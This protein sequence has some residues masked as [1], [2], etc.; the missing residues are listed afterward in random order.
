MGFLH[1]L[2]RRDAELDEEIKAHLT[3]AVRDRV[4]RGEDPAAAERAVRLEFGNATAIR[5]STRE[6]WGFGWLEEIGR[7]LRYALRGMRGSPGVTAVILLSMALGIGANTAMFSLV[8]SVM[9]RALPVSHP[10]EL[11]ELLQKYPGEPRGNGY[12]SR[13]SLE[14]YRE[15][16]RS[17]GAFTGMSIDNV[18]RV[19]VGQLESEMVAEYVLDN[20]F[21]MLGVRPVLGRAIGKEEAAVAVVSWALWNSRFERD[22]GV[23]GKR[24]MVN[25]K[26][27]VIVGV[28]PPAFT[29][30]R[31]NVQSD[32]WLPE[33]PKGGVALVARLRP[34]VSLEQA[35]AEMTTLFRFT[36]EERVA[37]D[38]TDPQ[39][40]K[41]QVELEPAAAG[42]ADVRDRV[43][44]PLAVLMAI[45][46]VLLLLACVN[47]A[48][49]LLA[50]GAGRAR[51]MSLRMSLGASRG[52]LIRQVMTESLLLSVLGTV[53][54][55]LFAYGG[56]HILLQI[57]DS[58]RPHERVHLLVRPDMTLLAFAAGLAVLTGLL[59]SVGP[60]LQTGRWPRW[61]GKGLVAVQVALSLLLVSTGAIFVANLADLKTADLGFRRDHVLLVNLDAGRG[62]LRGERQAVVYKELLERMRALPGV[63]SATLSA[64][65]PLHGAGA[66]GFG[67]VEGFHE[68]PEDRRWISISYVAPRYF[69]TMATP[70]LAGRE[71]RLQDDA[72]P[73]VAIINQTLARHF[74]AGRNPIGQRITM[75]HVTMTREPATYEIVGVAADA[76]YM[77][78]RE[79]PRRSIYF[80]AFRNG[81]V[82]GG[83]FVLRTSIDPEHVAGDV[84]SLLA[85][86]VP[87][88]PLGKVTTL[89][90]QIDSS[91]VP[92]RLMAALSGFFAALG[93]LLAGIGLYGLLG[94]MVARRT[95]EI[96]IRMALGATPGRML[97]MVFGE[98]LVVVLAGVAFGFPVAM[99][100]RTVATAVMADITAR[101]VATLAAA[102]ASI[103]AVAIAASLGPARRAARVD[104]MVSLRHD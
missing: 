38:S 69:E 7:D 12:W 22:P 32:L 102:G 66:S 99:W 92:Q 88:V 28:A 10:E 18:A 80:P 55:A 36:V 83:T 103:F 51:E 53:L 39:L 49:L 95:H 30:L 63:R 60:A 14:H 91:I 2:R 24:I 50:R 40:R 65:T 101:P 16:S 57:L 29:G 47:V 43:G 86:V 54:G 52:R 93:G 71:F 74:F 42:L 68:R 76:H 81:R 73:R 3:M 96:G 21:S 75:E 82:L 100:G 33:E 64:P 72:N 13:K 79:E 27:A 62:G 26:E 34:G 78:I 104:P 35:R 97:A 67:V 56:A 17:F 70:L 77:E 31:A 23:L 44:K 11:V 6:V 98:A 8:Y 1:W 61:F 25:G 94:Y 9:L 20:Y 46:A 90:D 85:E 5:E 37:A 87:G 59:F 19:R 89:S 45:V 84:R 15:N 4:A 48:G 58:G 41:L